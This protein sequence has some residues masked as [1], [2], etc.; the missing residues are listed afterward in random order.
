M[1]WGKIF[2]KHILDRGYNYYFEG[3]V[4]DLRKQ[5]DSLTATVCGTKEYEVEVTFAG[6]RIEDMQCSCPY[7]ESGEYCKHMAAVLYEWEDYDCVEEEGRCDEPM[8]QKEVEENSVMEIVSNATEEEVRKFLTQVLEKDEKLLERFKKLLRPEISKGDIKN[9]KRQINSIVRSFL[10]REQFINYYEANY[11]IEEI[12]AFLYE[13]VQMLLDNGWYLEAFELTTYIFV[14]IGNVDIDDSDGG[15]GILAS[16]CYEIWLDIL[17]RVELKAKKSMYEWFTSHLDGT[18]VD[19]LEE[20]IEKVL[21]NEFF[22]LE[23]TDAKLKFTNQKAKEL[24]NGA[25]TWSAN[26]HAG[27]WALRHLQLMEQNNGDG[28]NI[29]KYCREYWKYSDVRKYWIDK[30]I[31]EKNYENAIEVL[32]ESQKIDSEYRG[33]VCQ[34]SNKLKEVY[35]IVGKKEEYREQ[36]WKLLLKD[37]PGDIEIYHELKTQYLEEEWGEIR[38]KIFSNL[39]VGAHID[40]LYKEEKLYNRL[41]QYVQNS[42]GLTALREYES[43]LKKEYSQEILQKY[44]QE[45][46]EMATYT[47]DRKHYKQLVSILRAMNKISGGEKAVTE[48]LMHWRTAYKNRPAMLDELSKLK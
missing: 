34:H 13:D 40:R 29:E 19:Y 16:H 30:C 1:N 12:D 5:Q 39:P 28:E 17:K 8:K 38:E 10:G 18:I 45:V 27:K 48:I 26:Y 43:I 22:E 15:I 33:L 32:L 24:G 21:M 9:Y 31:R 3:V 2:K 47:A 11:F 46:N 42:P 36:L 44:A 23:F 35:R 41:I 7:A 37:N 25:D 4:E 6:D 14:T 20:Y